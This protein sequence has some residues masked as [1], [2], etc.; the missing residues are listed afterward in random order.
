MVS[1][2]ETLAVEI[3]ASN[4]CSGYHGVMLDEFETPK[5]ELD[6]L[7]LGMEAIESEASATLRWL[8]DQ[9]AQLAVYTPQ[10][11]IES[12]I[13]DLAAIEDA[14]AAPVMTFDFPAL[15]ESV[16][17]HCCNCACDTPPPEDRPFR[18]AGFDL[19]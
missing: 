13:Q 10:K 2:C 4:V 11:T 18:R 16:T 8:M 12:L 15:S 1:V 19:N 6:E 7:L 3:G 14:V 17:T 5:R 9:E